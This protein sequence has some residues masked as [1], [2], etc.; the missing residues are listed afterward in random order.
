[1]HKGN[2]REWKK[3]K[4]QKIFKFCSFEERRT[5]SALKTQNIVE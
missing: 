4:E 5:L 3:E 2:Y 1:M